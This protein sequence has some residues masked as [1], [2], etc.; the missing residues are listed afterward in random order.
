MDN[1]FWFKAGKN[2]GHVQSDTD[3]HGT[4]L[5]LG[6]DRAYGKTWR[7][8]AFV[9]YGMTSF[10]DTSAMSKFRDTRVGLY[11][12]RRGKKSDFM[13][14]VDGGTMRTHLQR[15]L[16]GLGLATDARYRSHL[17][18]IGGEYRYDLQ[19]GTGKIW[20]TSPYV[21]AQFS[22]L[23]QNGYRETGAGIYNHHVGS[24]TSNYFAAG[25]G[26][27][28]RRYLPN[29]SYGLR[30]GVKHAFAGADPK[31]SFRYEGYDGQSYDMASRQDKTHMVL[32]LSG[33]AEFAPGWTLTGEA[34][35]Q[36]GAHDSETM[37]FLT[38]RRMW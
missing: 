5:A 3:Y 14:Y 22:R 23:W 4:A 37:C 8:G 27:E 25:L 11:A 26:V 21:N 28:F 9:S 12:G 10:A 38:L 19:G 30:V 29:G 31:L 18:E 15:S 36:R 35:L 34:G 20:H 33:E 1:D 13:F 24:L 16:T 32:S 17:F 6:W 2:W 7:A